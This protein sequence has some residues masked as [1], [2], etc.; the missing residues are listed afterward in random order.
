MTPTIIKLAKRDPSDPPTISSFNKMNPRETQGAS[1]KK[2]LNKP[3]LLEP[4]GSQK[5][6]IIKGNGVVKHS[7]LIAPQHCESTRMLVRDSIR[8]FIENECDTMRS[9]FLVAAL[10]AIPDSPWSTF[11]EGNN[12][13][14]RRLAFLLKVF[15]VKKKRT[16]KFGGRALKGYRKKWF[17]EARKLMK[18]QNPT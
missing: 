6:P 2:K 11:C 18:S 13:N 16:I 12:L 9:P 10:C 7:N 3:A 1:G 4:K 15:F 5:I 17:I 8:I 14:C